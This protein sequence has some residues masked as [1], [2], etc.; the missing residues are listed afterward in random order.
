MYLEPAKKLII[1]AESFIVNLT[2]EILKLCK[3]YSYSVTH[4]YK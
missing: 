3:T 1:L 4:I 2:L